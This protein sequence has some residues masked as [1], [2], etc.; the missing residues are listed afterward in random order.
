MIFWKKFFKKTI[1]ILS[2]IIASVL[3]IIIIY[4][5]I[6]PISMPNKLVEKYLF[7]KI[8]RGTSMEE[9][10]KEIEDKWEIRRIDY[11][12]GIY[13]GRNG[14]SLDFIL[15]DPEKIV[16]DKF[17]DVCLGEYT[18]VFECFVYAYFI[19][20][21]NDKLIQIIVRKDLEAM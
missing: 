13:Y 3:I 5:I 16:G 6:H 9:A 1:K 10:I 12:H 18:I 21:E 4:T 14:R 2:I 8:D 15:E 17:I 11:E 20:D 7:L 19:F